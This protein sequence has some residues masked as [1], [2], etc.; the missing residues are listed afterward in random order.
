MTLSL[1]GAP[2]RRALSPKA[3]SQ[4]PMYIPRYSNTTRHKQK[5]L[6][7]ILLCQRAQIDIIILLFEISGAEEMEKG[8][9]ESLATT[10]KSYSNDLD[11]K[12]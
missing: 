9:G 4:I 1:L 10:N 8:G 2:R 11:A 5:R 7:I 6:G 12:G 3:I